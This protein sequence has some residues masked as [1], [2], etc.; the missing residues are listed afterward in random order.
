MFPTL[1]LA[2]I[3]GFAPPQNGSPLDSIARIAITRNLGVR[4]A[5]E[6][7]RQADAGVSQARGMFLPTVGIEARY[8]RF[9][10]V[11]N[12]GDFINPAYSALNQLIGRAEFPTNIDATLPYTQESKFRGAVPLFNGTLFANLAAARSIRD[13]RGAERATMV[14]RLDAD[15]RLAYLDYM[16]AQRAV[17]VWDATIPVI[18]ENVRCA[19]RLI[20]AGSATPDAVLSA[21]A[22]LAEAREQRAD[23]I[24]LRDAGLGGL[25][26]LMDRAADAPVPAL[27]DAALPRPPQLTR[28]DAQIAS[29]RREEFQVAGAAMGAAR[30]QRNSAKS[31]LLPSV[32]LA[33]D[34]GWQGNTYEFDRNHDVAVGSLVFSWSIFNGRQDAARLDAARSAQ[35]GAELQRAEIDRQVA[36]DVRTAWDALEV[37]RE[38]EAASVERLTSARAAFTLVDRRFTEGYAPHLEWS[39]A[40]ARLT[41]AELNVVLA[42]YTLAARIVN[43]E[44]AA[45]LRDL[46]LN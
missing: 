20:D 7:E 28:T 29:Q 37:A 19:Q 16:R 14:R 46:N 13:L 27:D 44:R 41:A 8:S 34:Y 31:S 15:V 11:M 10:G 45:A 38:N 23:A 5:S 35:R 1:I 21:R 22:D 17:D 42:R 3:A 4:R 39:D 12:L 36:L 25:N 2:A 26:L 33:V 43:L 40:R 18:A 30:A 6:I 32:A 24:R 9:S